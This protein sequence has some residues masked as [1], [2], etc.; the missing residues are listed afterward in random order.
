MTRAAPLLNKPPMA[1][2]GSDSGSPLI[3]LTARSASPERLEII[4]N[5]PTSLNGSGTKAA[6]RRQA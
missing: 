5:A 4:Y 1:G 6:R 3:T 2:G